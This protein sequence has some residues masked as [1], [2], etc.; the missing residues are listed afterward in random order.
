MEK[1]SLVLRLTVVIGAILILGSIVY[2]NKTKSNE[3]KSKGAVSVS[4]KGDTFDGTAF[5]RDTDGDG[6]FDWE[7]SLWGTD[8]NNPDTDGDGTSDGDEVKSGRDPLIPGPDD[9]VKV[10]TVPSYKR[11]DVE[12]LTTTQK[13]EKDF[14]NGIAKL[15]S[16]GQLT[17]DTLQTFILGLTQ[18]YVVKEQ[19]DNQYS[20]SDLEITSDPSAEAI[21]DYGNR[22]GAVAN[23]YVGVDFKKELETIQSVI[24]SGG[25]KDM[26]K[27]DALIANYASARGALLGV[28]TVPFAVVDA[29]LKILNGVSAIEKT[30]TEM[31]DNLTTDPL[32]S[33]INLSLYQQGVVLIVQGS[34][35]LANY[36]G[37]RN[38][39]FSQNE[40]GFILMNK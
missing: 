24:E 27:L 4:E 10:S 36:L 9:K 17:N 3:D 28:G 30:L 20:K 21:K 39:T 5:E 6:L 19:I 2:F 25:T 22:L 31:K 1:R 26:D 15:S 32:K 34:Q 16:E 7:E 38:I 18:E 40:P 23:A 8:L 11:T 14:Y 35:D 33:M 13:F 37:G 29:H 12:N